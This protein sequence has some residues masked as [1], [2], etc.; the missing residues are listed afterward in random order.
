MA[1]SIVRE[2]RDAFPPRS[3]AGRECAASGRVEQK[4]RQ[5]DVQSG[6]DESG[7]IGDIYHAAIE[8]ARWPDVTRRLAE[9]AGVQRVVVGAIDELDPAFAFLESHDL[10]AGE[11]LQLRKDCLEWLARCEWPVP[12]GSGPAGAPVTIADC[13]AVAV[14]HR[15]GALVGDGGGG[16]GVICLHQPAGSGRVPAAA[17]AFIGQLA[18]HFGR[19]LH[20]HRRRLQLERAI[21]GAAA[22]ESGDVAA[23]RVL[24]GDYLSVRYGLTE[25]ELAVCEQYLNL[26]SVEETSAALGVEMSTVRFHLKNIYEKTGQRTLP[27]LMR[28]LVESQLPL[29]AGS[30]ARKPSATRGRGEPFP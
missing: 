24:D 16:R 13:C 30:S 22:R 1:T 12:R 4:E 26:A 9:V 18:P 20:I 19:A 15:V 10:S 3:V 23:R 25:R 27:A 8:P 7:L 14:A 2:R 6:G 5:D 21:G 28:L 11:A 17:I 29:P